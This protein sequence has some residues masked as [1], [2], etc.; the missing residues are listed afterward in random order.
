ML[1]TRKTKCVLKVSIIKL[2]L[3]VQGNTQFVYH[4]PKLNFE[5]SSYQTN[6][7]TNLPLGDKD[8]YQTIEYTTFGLI[9][10]TIHPG[11]E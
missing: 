9:L 1:S 3:L 10:K 6:E 11:R 5:L 7:I 8:A 2:G 4:K